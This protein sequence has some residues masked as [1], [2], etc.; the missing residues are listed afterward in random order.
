M[1]NTHT[2]ISYLVDANW[3]L[4][5][6]GASRLFIQANSLDV[7]N[8]FCRIVVSQLTKHCDALVDL[9]EKVDLATYINQT[10]AE[11]E[12]KKQERK[13]CYANAIA[14]VLHLTMNRIVGREG[15]IPNFHEI[16]K[17]IIHEYGVQ[18]A[19]TKKVLEKVCPEYRLHFRQVDETGA[20]QAINKRRPGV[21]RFSLCNEQW[22]KFSAFYQKTPKEILKK[23]DVTGEFKAIY[24]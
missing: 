8:E 3:E 10:N 20:R 22:D 19:N 9:L 1:K 15:G 17:R 13:T 2:P 21:A 11:F 18:G 6:S 4:P 24:S 16:C 12:P 14:A 7:V 5:P 23:H